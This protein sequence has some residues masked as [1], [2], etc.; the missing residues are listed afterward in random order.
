M[1]PAPPRLAPPRAL[2]TA[3]QRISPRPAACALVT[4]D[5]WTLPCFC[6][7]TCALA[8]ADQWAPPRPAAPLVLCCA[9]C[10][11]VAADQWIPSRPAACPLDNRSGSKKCVFSPWLFSVCVFRRFCFLFF[12]HDGICSTSFPRGNQVDGLPRVPHLKNQTMR[13]LADRIQ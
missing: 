5:Q 13:N 4:A 2:A 3:D 9:A 1:D 6:P 11:L 10:A 12:C 7:A 8:T